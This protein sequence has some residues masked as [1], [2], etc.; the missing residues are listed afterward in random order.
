MQTHVILNNYI[1]GTAP[2]N[3]GYIEIWGLGSVS[4]TS[5]SI[6]TGSR[7]IESV[8]YDYNST[9]Q[10]CDYWKAQWSFSTLECFVQQSPLPQAATVFS[11]ISGQSGDKA[12][13]MV[14]HMEL[15][16]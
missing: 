5:V 1:T 8:P 3:L 9:T 6:I 12:K 2:L 10:V 14:Y 4:I 13:P 11:L 15:K 7:L 16:I